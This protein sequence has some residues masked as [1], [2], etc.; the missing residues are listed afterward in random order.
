MSEERASSSLP[1]VSS[2][3][4]EPHSPA[5]GQWQRPVPR[6][7]FLGMEFVYTIL[8]FLYAFAMESGKI[9]FFIQPIR[10]LRFDRFIFVDRFLN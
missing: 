10:T 6:V 9:N 1:L 4:S 3:E 7:S 8:L 5:L 2:L